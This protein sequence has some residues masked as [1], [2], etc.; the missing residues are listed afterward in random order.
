MPQD[1]L[2]GNFWLFYHLPIAAG[3]QKHFLLS[4]SV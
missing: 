3:S 1:G 4:P 2:A